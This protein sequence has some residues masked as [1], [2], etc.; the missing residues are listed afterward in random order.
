MGK[1]K[2]KHPCFELKRPKIRNAGSQIVYF[3]K[4]L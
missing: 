1:D 2:E 4:P 3:T